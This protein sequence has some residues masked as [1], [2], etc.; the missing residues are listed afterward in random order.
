M[1]GATEIDI[2]T[3]SELLDQML[4]AAAA[5]NEAL[6]ALTDG[7][8]EGRYAQVAHQHAV[9]LQHPGD[10]GTDPGALLMDL[11]DVERE[12]DDRRRAADRF[13]IAR[14]EQQRL[15][16][17]AAVATDLARRVV[18][19]E[20]YEAR[21]EVRNAALKKIDRS[22][23]AL[24]AAFAEFR[25]AARSME[26]PHA[27]LDASRPFF[28]ADVDPVADWLR[29]RLSR[30]APRV[31][32]P[33]GRTDGVP[34]PATAAALDA[35]RLASVDLRT[36]IERPDPDDLGTEEARPDPDA[37]LTAARA[38]LVEA[39]ALV[40]AEDG[41]EARRSEERITHELALIDDAL[42]ARR[43]ARS[44]FTRPTTITEEPAP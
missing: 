27:E 13:K 5:R 37:P 20:Q 2:D 33:S 34:L 40:R 3:G 14:V 35:A 10:P 6:R 15:D 1:T 41:D 44:I 31:F 24:I 36:L 43:A 17:E 8:L 26:A 32:S 38:E 30:E 9:A 7:E 19:V 22:T 16:A 29:D 21:E 39:L 11:H 23:N 12:V 25:V 28:V 18:L 4:V 42:K